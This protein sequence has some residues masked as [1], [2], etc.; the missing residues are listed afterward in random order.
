MIYVKIFIGHFLGDWLLQGRWVGRGK[1]KILYTVFAPKFWLHIF[2][3]TL[4]LG[5]FT[6][7][8]DWRLLLVAASHAAIDYTKYRINFPTRDLVEIL[9]QA[10]HFLS[11]FL[12]ARIEV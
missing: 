6:G 10:L 8:W 12:I 11:Y 1:R 7:W 2:I 5:I 9:D 3:V 4:S